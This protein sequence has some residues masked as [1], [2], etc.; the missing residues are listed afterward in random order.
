[1]PVTYSV[2]ESPESAVTPLRAPVSP[3]PGPAR[4]RGSDLSQF[5]PGI[6]SPAG[7]PPSWHGPPHGQ[8]PVTGSL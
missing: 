8:S 5:S 4:V 6:E 7:G 3:L 1:M 2:P